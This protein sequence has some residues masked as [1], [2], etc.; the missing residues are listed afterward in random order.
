M[1]A[2]IIVAF[3]LFAAAAA[4]QT[5][6]LV[7]Q[8]EF[9]GNSLDRSK[10]NFEINCDGGGNNELQC[11]TD[12]PN[13]LAVRNG[14]LVITAIPQNY[15]GKQ[16][17]SSRITTAKSAAWKYGRIDF[18]AKLPGGKYLWPAL[19][20]MPRDSV[21][22]WWAASGEIDIMESRGGDNT[23][24]STLHFG[25]SWPNNVYQGSGPQSQSFD[26]TKDFHLYSA[27]W[28]PE[29]IQFLIDNRVYYTQSLQRNFWSGRGA[30]PY[31]ANGQPFDQNFFIIINLAVGGGF[32]GGEANSLTPQM[33]AQW[34]G[35]SFYVDYV[36]VYQLKDGGVNVNP[37]PSPSASC[38]DMYNN[39]QCRTTSQ[40]PSQLDA[41]GL[42][43]SRNWLCSA[44][45][46]YCGAI[47]DGAQYSGCNAAE[48]LSYAMNLY[49]AAFG[50]QQGVGACS[51]GG[52]G[53]VVSATV[54]PSPSTG[55]GT[56]AT[57]ASSG[58]NHCAK[59]SY[60]S[61]TACACNGACYSPDAYCCEAGT[62]LRQVGQCSNSAATSA[63]PASTTTNSVTPAT[64]SSSA[65]SDMFNS[66][67][68]RTNSQDPTQMDSGAVNGARNWLCGAYGQYCTAI[69]N[70]GQY[71]SCNI[72]QQVSYAMNQYYNAF[73]W[74]GASACSFGGIAKVVT[75]GTTA[76]TPCQSMFSS[77]KC[78]T[79]TS[80]PSSL[81]TNQVNNARTWLC[82]AYPQHCTA[83]NGGGQ[84]NT[85]NAAEQ[86]S[87]AM[88]NYYAQF[89]PSQG[90]TACDFGGLGKLQA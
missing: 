17:T 52:L 47:N 32:F 59:A 89:G 27:I 18:N 29:S 25:G 77:L 54:A 31:T 88:N 2:N 39:L 24:E 49:Y 85:C 48:K 58:S 90:A 56:P 30:S 8:D 28:T 82:S 55:T 76:Q 60:C 81:D 35:A 65:C 79:S 66:L 80:N 5:Y 20:M 44:Y 67:T 26:M 64:S 86:I 10:W 38:T 45:P 36:R 21:Y 43:S 11:Y 37:T 16:Y 13:N 83:I 57:S 74:Q 40:N 23:Q 12:S 34:K 78:R 70:G 41:A 6:Q 73:S 71:S 3:C 63:N 72:A 51:F 4:Q 84:F 15:N 9:D 69:Q 33:A 19:W 14:S 50:P 7:W 75:Q 1:R 53:K 68:C 87:F 46:Q 61:S 62:S 22:G 42:T